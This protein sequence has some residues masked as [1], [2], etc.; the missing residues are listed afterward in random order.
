[1]KREQEERDKE[2]IKRK[3]LFMAEQMQYE[4]DFDET[5]PRKENYSL[6]PTEEEIK[7]TSPPPKIAKK[8]DL[9]DEEEDDDEDDTIDAVDKLI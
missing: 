4:D 1:M 6:L 5:L 3:V 2:D 7:K 9:Q 8:G